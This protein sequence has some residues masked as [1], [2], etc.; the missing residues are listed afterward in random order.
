[1]AT[2]NPFN[3][4]NPNPAPAAPTPAAS[5]QAQQGPANSNFQNPQGTP[6]GGNGNPAP[7]SGN[8]MDQF[9]S[10]FGVGGDQQ[11][12]GQQMSAPPQQMTQAP[13]QNNGQAAPAYDGYTQAWDD[14]AIRSKFGSVRF[15]QSLPPELRQRIASGDSEAMMEAIDH[16]GREAFLHSTRMSHGLIDKGVKT[17][18]DK[19]GTG[20]DDRFRDYEVRRQTPTNDLYSHPTVAPTYQAM[21]SFIAKQNPNLSAQQ[22]VEQTEQWFNGMSSAMAAKQNPQSQSQES[23]G[24][25]WA[26]TFGA[27]EPE[28]QQFNP[29]G[30]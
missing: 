27:G 18:L 21:K 8:P 28:G 7:Q 23:Q 2:W 16:V 15:S 26:A 13:V 10:L 1:M 11:Q 17:G 22:V 19:F 30:F 25:D 6:T 20:L 14:G 4:T 3:R 9:N 29:Q 12:G 5:Q 24:T